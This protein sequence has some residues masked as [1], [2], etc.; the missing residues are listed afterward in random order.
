MILA[1]SVGMAEGLQRR[2]KERT[3]E[4]PCFKSRRLALRDLQAW[5]SKMPTPIIKS[6]NVTMSVVGP[7]EGALVSRHMTRFSS[8][9]YP[10]PHSKVRF[11]IFYHINII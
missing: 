3:R 5:P 9:G 11:Y 1:M 2:R 6:L 7:R 8:N 4:D 10:R